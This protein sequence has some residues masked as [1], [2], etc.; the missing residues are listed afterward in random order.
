MASSGMRAFLRVRSID[1]AR[2]LFAAFAATATLAG[3]TSDPLNNDLQTASIA[4]GSP[5]KSVCIVSALGDTYSVQKIGITVF[6]NALDKVPIE[7]WGLDASVASKIGSQLSHRFDARRIDYPRGAF[8][9]LEPPKSVFSSD[10]KDRREEIRD[11]ARGIVASHTCD[12]C[13]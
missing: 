4:Q 10:Y 5:R 1:A 3:C 9:S 8:A 11:I 12:L 6:G 2:L 7:A 13:L